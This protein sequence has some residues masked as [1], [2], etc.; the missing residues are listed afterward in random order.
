MLY[1]P[2]LLRLE[3]VSAVRVG[4][5]TC[6]LRTILYARHNPEVRLPLSLHSTAGKTRLSLLVFAFRDVCLAGRLLYTSARLSLA[7]FTL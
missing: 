6:Y 2:R 1:R 4:R 5:L 7:E 3:S